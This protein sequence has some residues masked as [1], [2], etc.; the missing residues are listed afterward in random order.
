MLVGHNSYLHVLVASSSS[1]LLLPTVD[2]NVPPLTWFGTT[3]ALSGPLHESGQDALDQGQ[4]WKERTS[5]Y[6]GNHVI[7]LGA[8]LHYVT[9]PYDVGHMTV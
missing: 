4:A 6:A 2:V 8:G 9:K 7:H 5:H 3:A 1:V